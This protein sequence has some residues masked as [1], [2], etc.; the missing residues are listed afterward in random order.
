MSGEHDAL[1]PRH[2]DVRAFSH[3]R[4]PGFGDCAPSGRMRL[5]AIA[6]W[7]QDVAY[8]D[9]EDAG[10]ERSAVWVVRRTRI[11][12][13]RF[14]RFGEHF[15]LTTF[16]GGLGR[17]W[18]ERR[19]DIVFTGHPAEGREPGSDGEPAGADVEAVSLWVHLDNE[20]WRPTPLTEAEL[21]TYGGAPTR[22]V[23]ARLR[24]PTPALDTDE[25]AWTFRATECD[26]ADHVNNAAYWLPVE[27]E[28]LGGEEPTQLDV[29]IEYRGPAQPGAK[30]VLRAGEYRWIVAED[31]ELHASVRLGG[32][33]VG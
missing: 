33:H 1:G 12:V 4:R 16:C 11:R 3:A 9:V 22:R 19:T 31:G 15:E 20:H 13:N 17:M 14:P 25:V 8:A 30:R 23:S 32:P 5:D 26:I 18:A 21:T 10:L 27:E 24:H 2:P 29:E 28:L 6:G 7:L